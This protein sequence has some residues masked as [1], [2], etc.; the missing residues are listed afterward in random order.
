MT[1]ATVESRRC[2]MHQV[3]SDRISEAYLRRRVALAR[4]ETFT[5]HAAHALNITDRR[6]YLALAASEVIVAREQ[7]ALIE[8]LG[9]ELALATRS[10]DH[11]QVGV[12]QRAKPLKARSPFARL[13]NVCTRIARRL[14]WAVLP[15]PISAAITASACPATVCRVAMRAACLLHLCCP[16]CPSSVSF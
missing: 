13:R 16:D 8:S 4:A 3:L 9:Q 11:V 6:H 5:M 7:N 10:Q 2:F 1:S 15:L 12:E 14:T